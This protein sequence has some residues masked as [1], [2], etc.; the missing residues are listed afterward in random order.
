MK[1]MAYYRQVISETYSYFGNAT[2]SF[3]DEYKAYTEGSTMYIRTLSNAVPSVIF[4]RFEEGISR[5]PTTIFYVSTVND[6][7]NQITMSNRNAYELMMNLLNDYFI[8]WRELTMILVRDIKASTISDSRLTLVFAVSFVISVISIIG[9]RQLFNRFIDD[10]EKPIDLFLTI[11]KQKFEELK[12]STESFMNKLLNKFFGNEENDDDVQVDTGIKISS[13]DII[14]AKFKQKTQ[15]KQ[16]IRNGPEYFL[17]FLKIFIFFLIFQGYMTFKFFYMETG[18][19]S[20][21]KYVDVFSSM[22]YSQ[23]DM[24]LSCNVAKQFF[25][26]KTIPIFNSTKTEEIFMTNFLNIS[27][28]FQEM[29]QTV[30]SSTQYLSTSYVDL[31]MA[32]LNNNISDRVNSSRVDSKIYL[33]TPNYG[34]KA[35]A[36]RYFELIRFLSISY[37]DDPKYDYINTPQFLEINSILTNIVR[38]WYSKQIVSLNEGLTSYIDQKDLVILSTFIVL[39]VTI[40]VVYFLIWKSFEDNL[41]E[42]LKTSVDLINL[43]P[44]SIKYIIV[45]KINEEDEV[46]KE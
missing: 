4:N 11:K 26:D 10:R 43:I 3:S 1:E 5:I 23:S 14:I 16:S 39:I 6:N 12:F 20:L 45:Q 13:D 31:F 33:G 44:E 8:R 30:Y 34:M 28:S 2:I 15:Y 22:Q 37:Y 17:I 29:V 40:L 9:I 27:N 24:V 36:L 41:K 42:L 32:D 21:D 35:V 25:H 46:K 18:L 7:Y 38:L 19:V